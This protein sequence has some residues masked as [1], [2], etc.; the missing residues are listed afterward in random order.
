[1]GLGRGGGFQHLWTLPLWTPASVSRDTEG[2]TA[3]EPT[4]CQALIHLT[5]SGGE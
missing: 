4:P 3:R 2:Q 5:E 1:M